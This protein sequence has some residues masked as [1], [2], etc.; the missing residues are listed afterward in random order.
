MKQQVFRSIRRALFILAPLAL[1]A[2]ATSRQAEEQIVLPSPSL[3]EI[4]VGQSG[5]EALDPEYIE[6]YQP[7]VRLSASWEDGAVRIGMVNMSGRPLRIGPGNF[8]VIVDKE[9]HR[10]QPGD[11]VVEFPIV[12]LNPNEGVSGRL[13][14]LKL[15]DLTGRHLVFNHRDVRP[16]RCEILSPE[17]K[18]EPTSQTSQTTGED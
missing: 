17:P 2:C 10:A 4:G 5:S 6:R 1:G 11:V 12:S 8:G 15:G 14:F 7:D 9:L 3:M 13:R 18:D 16:S